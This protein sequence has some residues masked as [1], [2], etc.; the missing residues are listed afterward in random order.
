MKEYVLGFL[1]SF[2]FEDVVLIRKNKPDWQ[3]GKLNGLGGLIEPT[4]PSAEAAMRREFQEECGA[5]IDN[6]KHF[7]NMEGSNWRV[8]CFVAFRSAEY[9]NQK[10]QTTTDEG[11]GIGTV[12]FFN[13]K[14]ATEELLPN[15]PWLCAMARAFTL[16]HQP[17]LSV[18]YP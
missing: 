17:V 8:Y 7:A 4:D 14:D 5:D 15:I 2:G 11:V 9:L 3:A 18:F 12:Q 13:D 6:W 1:F 16:G 10:V